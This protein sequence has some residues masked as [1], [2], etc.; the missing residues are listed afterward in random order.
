[1]V[2]RLTPSRSV[3]LPKPGVACTGPQTPRS[4][5]QASSDIHTGGA[6]VGGSLDGTPTRQAMAAG[7]S[8]L[9]RP[10]RLRPCELA[11][12]RGVVARAGTPRPCRAGR[13]DGMTGAMSWA[14]TA[15][16]PRGKLHRPPGGTGAAR[17]RVQVVR[18]CWENLTGLSV[19]GASRQVRTCQPSRVSWSSGGSGDRAGG[20]LDQA[21]DDRVR[22]AA[23]ADRRHGVLPSH[24]PARCPARAARVGSG[25]HAAVGGR[26]DR[27]RV[28]HAAGR[29]ARWSAGRR[30]AVV[31]ASGGEHREPWR[32]RRSS[33]ARPNRAHHRGL[34]IVRP[35]RVVRA[36]YPSGALQ[37]P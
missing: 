17:P 11:S 26:D 2:A 37:R 25:A 29:V 21:D 7:R 18:V 14:V 15:A 9:D 24:A 33:R 1:M 5:V 34:A 12:G 13:P 10:G 30:A 19:R 16:S 8:R 27:G 6:P 4:M 23:G 22:G 31:T 3:A 35:H 28:D 32:Q 36:A 20:H